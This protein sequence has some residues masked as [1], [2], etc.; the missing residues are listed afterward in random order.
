MKTIERHFA[1]PDTPAIGSPV[2]T[3]MLKVLAKNPNM[4]FDAAKCEA[5]ALLEKAA[6]KWRYRV[7]VVYSPEEAETRRERLRTAFK[8]VTKAA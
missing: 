7:P 5:N 3:L 4:S 2:G 8:P 1:R 6:R